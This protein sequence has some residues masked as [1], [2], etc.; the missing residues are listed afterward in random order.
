M[1]NLNQFIKFDWDAFAA[2]KKFLYL[3][4]SNWVDHD[5]QQLMGTRVEVVIA[6]DK[7]DYKPA[8][9]GTPAKGNRF[10]KL[11][12]KVPGAVDL[13]ED[14]YI[15]IVNPVATVYGDYRNQLSVK[16]DSVKQVAQVSKPV[17]GQ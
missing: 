14:S 7:T 12:I 16:A 8:A 11:T 10:E 5:T 9:D 4:Q 6:S 13:T 2:G 1:R 15:E 3:G 17:K